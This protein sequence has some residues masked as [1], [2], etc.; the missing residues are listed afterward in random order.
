MK[1]IRFSIVD[2]AEGGAEKVLISI[3]KHLPREKYQITLFLFEK[4]G[5]YLKDVPLD[6]ELKY[7][8]NT[9]MLPNWFLPFYRKVI[10]K[11]AFRLLMYVPSLIYKITGVKVTDI[12]VAYLQDTTYLLKATQFSRNKIAWMHCSVENTPVYRAGLDKN[13]KSV[14]KIVCVSEAVKIGFCSL[15]PDCSDKL[16]Y[17]YNPSPIKLIEELSQVDSITYD[18]PTIIAVGRLAKEKG[19]DILIKAI[20]LLKAKSHTYNLKIVGS[21]GEFEYLQELVKSLNLESSVELLGFQDNPYKFLKAADLFVLSSY[22][23][24]LGQV[25][26]EAL[27][28]GVP[29]VSTDCKSGP[30]EVL[31]N[32]ECGLLV[33]VG[34][35]EKLADGIELMMTNV[36]LRE[37]FVANGLKRAQDFDLP[38]IMTQIEALFD[39][40]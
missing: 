16:L 27:C 22:Y 39:E 35:V 12:D 33:P 24:G 20:Y 13:L 26:V 4:T 37:E 40:I 3:L 14:D 1:S 11:I 6:V 17:I 18:A 36:E 19:F 23:E 34:D 7:L 25:L 30:R 10:R 15:L 9:T 21:G 32:G 8:I 38:K 29:I 2:L 31:Q 5:V 28:L